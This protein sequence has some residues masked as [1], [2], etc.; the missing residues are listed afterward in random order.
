MIVSFILWFFKGLEPD[1]VR[2]IDSLVTTEAFLVTLIHDEMI[3]A[4][5]SSD[6]IILMRFTMMEV[7]N[8]EQVSFFIDDNLVLFFRQG[9]KLMLTDHRTE[10]DFSCVH[11]S[12]PVIKKRIS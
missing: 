1:V 2:T 8:I 12:V 9:Y 3:R 5:H 11:L 4:P 7:V 6:L 10:N